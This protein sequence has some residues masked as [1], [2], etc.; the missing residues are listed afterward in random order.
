MEQKA[1]FVLLFVRSWKP[2]VPG[3]LRGQF[4]SRRSLLTFR[5]SLHVEPRLRG[6]AIGI[7]VEPVDDDGPG[8]ID[9]RETKKSRGTRAG[10]ARDTGKMDVDSVPSLDKPRMIRTASKVQLGLLELIALVRRHLRN[11]RGCCDGRSTTAVPLPGRCVRF[12][13]E[14]AT[15]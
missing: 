5:C 15:A 13:M 14:D 10:S 6:C 2:F 12:M 8:R 3:F 4:S 7:N 9:D 1:D 11:V